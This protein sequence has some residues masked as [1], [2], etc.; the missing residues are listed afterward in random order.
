MNKDELIAK[1]RTRFF[2]VDED[3]MDIGGKTQDGIKVWAIG[4]F[5]LTDDIITKKNLTFYTK[6]DIAYWGNFE[7]NPPTP[8]P[9]ITFTDRVNNF[10]ASKIEDKTIKFAHIEQ[11]SELT[12]K[13]RITAVMPDK[14]EKNALISEDT[15]NVFSI[16]VLI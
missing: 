11:I 14:S 2:G 10:I 8:T 4:V 13:A 7:P 6:G 5:D 12:K 3:G 9:V 15:P 1:L 16:E